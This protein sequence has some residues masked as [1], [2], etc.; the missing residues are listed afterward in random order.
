MALYTKD[1]FLKEY[2]KSGWQ[3]SDADYRLA[4]SRPD[5]GM[6]MLTYARDYQNAHDNAGRNKAHDNMEALR[7]AYGGYSG[8]E[9]GSGF[10]L[11]GNTP[12]SFSYDP[13]TDPL[14]AAYRKQYLREGDRQTRDTLAS[15]AGMTGGVPS[16]AAVSAAQ[17]AGNYYNAQLTDKIPELYQMYYN[18]YRQELAD[19]QSAQSAQASAYDDEWQRQYELAQL[20]AKYGDTS[21]LYEL[22][23]RNWTPGSGESAGGSGSENGGTGGTTGNPVY[24]GLSNED[25]ELYDALVSAYGGKKIPASDWDDLVGYIPQLSSW[26]FYIMN[27]PQASGESSGTANNPIT[28]QGTMQ[29][30]NDWLKKYPNMVIPYSVWN[31]LPYNTKRE[32]ESMG[33]TVG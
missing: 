22:M 4:T 1:D 3:F 8:G 27:T 7:R 28:A 23:G 12:T 24:E 11:T 10:I 2:A 32:L 26:G 9:D 6:N 17:Q 5:V 20:A 30:E 14:Y 19:Q 29:N 25:K 13:E 31:S 15:Y 18:Q 33:F 16:T 21:L